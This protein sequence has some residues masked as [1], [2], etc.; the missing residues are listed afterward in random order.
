LGSVPRGAFARLVVVACCL[1]AAACPRD[2]L[3]M[4]AIQP[5][6]EAVAATAESTALRGHVDFG[7]A[8][9]QAQ[10]DMREVGSGATV[11]LIDTATGFTVATTVS[12]PEGAFDLEFASGWV[13]V[14][15]A[16]Y[17]LEAVKGLKAGTN[18]PNRVGADVARV[19]TIAR[20]QGG[21]ETVSA[22]TIMVNPTTTALSILLSLRSMT[23]A[24][25]GRRMDPASLL[26]VMQATSG[27][28]S[29]PSP[30]TYASEGL[31]PASLVKG[32]YLL[33]LNA[34][35]QDKDPFQSVALDANDPL[36]NT[37]RSQ[38]TAPTVA[39]IQPD[40]QFVGG[41]I[42]L[43][44]AGFSQNAGDNLVEFSTVSGGGVPATVKS[45]EAGGTRLVV[46]V[47]AGAVTGPV[48]VTFG[49]RKALGP[50]FYLALKTGHEALD[51]AGNLYV[52]N[53]AFGT[54]VTIAQDGGVK[55]FAA[56]LDGPRNLAVKDGKLYVASA[57][58]KKGVVVLDL[59]APQNGTSN[60]GAAGAIADPRGIAFDSSGKCYVADGAASKVWRIDGAAASPA[61]LT[62][63]AGSLNNPH[64]LAFG[65]DGKLYVANTGANTVVRIDVTSLAVETFLQGFSSPWGLA[66][67]SLGNLY[68]SNNKGNSIYRREATGGA[69]KPYADMPSPGGIVAD[70]GGYVY[71]IDNTSNNVY[72]I[73][74]DGDSAL[75]ASGISS[76]TGV[77]KVGN[78][79][80][81]LSQTNNSLM[82]VDLATTVLSTVARGFNSPFGLVYDDV[83]DL[84]Y[85]SNPGNGTITKVERANGR[86][87][88]VLTGTGTG[89]GGA[90]GLAYRNGRLYMR[91][92]RKVMAYDVTNFGAAP[93]E[94]ESLM[95]A[96]RGV[97]G[98]VS[99]G[100]NSGSYYIAAG[101]SPDGKSRILR[102]VGDGQDWGSASGANKVVVFKDSGGD[103]N[104]SDPRDV[105]VDAA[106]KVWVINRGN[107]KLTS[108][109]PDASVFLPAITGGVSDPYGVN[110]DASTVWVANY[111]PKTITGYSRTTGALVRT[112]PT[113]SDSPLNI[114]FVGT[115]M[116]VTTSNGIAKVTSYAT[117]PTYSLIYTALA[118]YT[119]IEADAGGNLYVLNGAGRKVAAD[120]SGD[121]AWYQN[122]HGPSF[123]WQGSG[124]DFWLTDSLRFTHTNGGYWGFRLIG[125]SDWIVG[126]SHAGID[127]N[128]NVF[129]NSTSICS[130]DVVGRLKPAAL[131]EEWTYQVWNPITCW[132]PNT[133][134]FAA[135]TRGNFYVS[136]RD[137]LEIMVIDAAGGYRWLPGGRGSEYKTYG[138]WV[139]TDGTQLFQTVQSHH[140]VERVD[141]ATG[142]R[143]VLPYGLSAAEL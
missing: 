37:L 47:P 58:S 53:E 30:Y 40:T 111:G 113:G 130:A 63:A 89:Y 67:D 86:V 87:T 19:R 2:A 66:F 139:E 10:A 142:A 91:S 14:G 54:V 50:T 103:A 15:G 45:V 5:A 21:W 31:L 134:A 32:A 46:T 93:L 29:D 68:V 79:L 94:Y 25:A 78:A 57:G 42:I 132:V 24:G 105:A 8:D 77:V 3:R 109:N 138:S 133:G 62:V 85:V 101:H 9:R 17:Y 71:A 96:N 65:Q 61:A 88:T 120:L 1:L 82:K 33:V 108:Y 97:S 49:G 84:F 121:V 100:P 44:G 129:L 75:F 59:S 115:T 127:S 35:A 34:L 76:P 56:G 126:P 20:F 48:A 27:T 128:G 104:L 102:V 92:S 55:T 119:D 140:R 110:A 125:A 73:T 141:T 137:N 60:F 69:L 43:I 51:S 7:S 107:N 74:P 136:R 122:Y 6:R 4:P 12:T 99:G 116:Y 143:T 28:P 39:A 124:G 72:R 11:S 131:Q 13:P 118:G 16:I 22:G 23:P 18:I 41:D 81:V 80:Y 135:D 90:W 36:Y 64:G 95:Q 52:S 106:G 98:D 26:G 112:I 117:A 114:C 38:T 83:R 70:R 123:F